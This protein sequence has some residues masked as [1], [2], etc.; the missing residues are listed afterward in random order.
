MTNPVTGAVIAETPAVPK[1]PVLREIA[2]ATSPTG[3]RLVTVEEAV[4]AAGP[5]RQEFRMETI[6]DPGGGT[7]T[8]MVR[9]RPGGTSAEAPVSKPTQS[10]L[11]QGITTATNQLD[12]LGQIRENLDESFLNLPEQI[13]QGGLALAERM[14]ITLSPEQRSDLTKFTRF[15]TSTLRNLNRLLNELSGAAISPAEAKR[16]QAELPTTDDSPSQFIAKIQD[17]EEAVQAAI[18][19]NQQLLESGVE[20]LEFD[21]RG[22]IVGA[23]ELEI[24]MLLEEERG[25]VEAGMAPTDLSGVSDDELL[26]MLAR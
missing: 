2:D 13:K 21:K 22:E 7:R 5:P 10:K 17:A 14:G 26:E 3:T 19:R 11:E 12:R 24:F 23:P 16:L 4:G 25:T 9:G 15:R 8:I 18:T 6:T 20:S 1:R